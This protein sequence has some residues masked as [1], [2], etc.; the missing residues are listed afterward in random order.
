MHLRAALFFVWLCLACFVVPVYAAE[1]N[2]SIHWDASHQE[3]VTEIA[4]LAESDWQAHLKTSYAFGI[5]PD[6]LWLRITLHDPLPPDAQFWFQRP[7]LDQVC[8]HYQVQA[9]WQKQCRLATN[10]MSEYPTEA[11]FDLS[12]LTASKINSEASQDVFLQIQSHNMIAFG[13][14][15]ESRAE[16]NRALQRKNL[17]QFS[18]LGAMAM[19][20]LYFLLVFFRLKHQAYL[21]QALFVILWSSFWF[22][23]VIEYRRLLPDL[24]SIFLYQLAYPLVLGA[25]FC[26]LQALRSYTREDLPQWIQKI[27]GA[28]QVFI[29]L[30]LIPLIL[31]QGQWN[32]Q[33]IR[34]LLFALPLVLVTG[35]CWSLLNKKRASASYLGIWTFFHF[36]FVILI[37]VIYGILPISAYILAVLSW[38]QVITLMLLSLTL[39]QQVKR[40]QTDREQ[41]LVQHLS[42][43]TGHTQALEIQ[44][45]ERTVDLE[46]SLQK[47]AANNESK[48][49]LFSIL[50][51]DLRNPFASLSMLLGIMER[52]PDSLREL[53]E[54]V[55]N[56]KKQVFGISSS[57][58]NM[59]TWAR[60]EMLGYPT[61]ALLLDPGESFKQVLRLHQ[62][63]ADQ[64]QI[65]FELDL[66]PTAK[67]CMD[68]NHLQVILRNFIDNALKFTP[69]GGQI[70]LSTHSQ[71]ETVLLEIKDSGLG[72]S[73]AELDTLLNNQLETARTGTAG[74][75]GIGLGFKLCRAYIE[76][77]QGILTIESEPDQGTTVCIAFPAVREPLPEVRLS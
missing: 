39:A 45:A 47:L 28:V 64:K 21:W 46:T 48:N 26:L 9:Q 7:N 52:N 40:L 20:A 1:H 53:P 22:G 58:D 5:N 14:L 57:L 73:S 76:A 35:L 32:L 13:W 41:M 68:P 10:Q 56:L 37:L 60:D 17:I 29:L 38:M 67:V 54:I 16:L 71:G 27:M 19:L 74:E 77:N 23:Y 34:I 51:H 6:T 11:V 59:L 65:L 4:D 3:S 62:T 63:S 25:S 2:V 30:G 55:S 8:L 69:V 18:A 42:V 43:V 50:A 70:H 33:Q 61:Q 44:V 66:D 75:K 49:R 24:W 31:G 36:T 12:T 72:M 15:I